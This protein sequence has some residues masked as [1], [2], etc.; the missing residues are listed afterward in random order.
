M[1]KA[2]DWAER[3]QEMTALLQDETGRGWRDTLFAKSVKRQLP[4]IWLTEDV[5][6]H[7]GIEI[8]EA[9]DALLYHF[10]PIHFVIWL[11]FHTNTRLRVLAKGLDKKELAKL[12]RK[13]QKTAEQRKLSGLPPED[14]DHDNAFEITALDEVG[15]PEDM[16]APLWEVP[17]Q[18]GEWRRQPGQEG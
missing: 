2:Q 4:Y 8:G 10:H 18:P 9:W 14:D 15:D 16:L 1:V 7:A 11:T 12:R 6:K 3:V 5:A 13:E 17:A